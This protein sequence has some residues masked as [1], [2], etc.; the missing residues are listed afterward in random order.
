[1][2]TSRDRQRLC[3]CES[4]TACRGDPSPQGKEFSDLCLTDRFKQ[5]SVSVLESD[6]PEFCHW[7][8]LAFNFNARD[9]GRLREMLA[10]PV[11][12]LAT[13]MDE[14]NAASRKERLLSRDVFAVSF[15]PQGA[16]A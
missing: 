2:P 4:A 11:G 16:A 14:A 12:A 15:L 1:M 5:Q 9:Q 7:I 13:H 6:E 3:L 10:L 8:R